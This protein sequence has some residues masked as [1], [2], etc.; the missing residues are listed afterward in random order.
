MLESGESVPGWARKPKRATR[1]WKDEG[2]TLRWLT[3]DLEADEQEIFD[4]KLKSP[5]QIE[6]LVGKTAVPDDL[7]VAQS[8]GFNL[9]RDSDPKA[10]PSGIT[11]FD[12][13]P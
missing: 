13:L 4:R 12:A 2:E 3:E 1:R 9:C 8:S 6:K 7:I 10:L 11:D 5:A